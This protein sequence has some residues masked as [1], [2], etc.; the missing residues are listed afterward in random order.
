MHDEYVIKKP[1]LCQERWTGGKTIHID[2]YEDE[3]DGWILETADKYGN[4]T[5]WKDSFN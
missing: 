3:E 1:P 4:S 2:I 5:F